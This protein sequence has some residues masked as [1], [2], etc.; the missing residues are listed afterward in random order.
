MSKFG[1]L[2]DLNIPVLLD[3]YTEWNEDS[4][5]MNPVLREVAASMGNK[6]KVIKIDV[7][8]N[9]QLAEALRVKTLPT[10]MI[11]KSGEMKWR[12]SG[13]QDAATLV[14]ILKEYV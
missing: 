11:Y 12:Q 7:D 4:K 6:V 3:F 8:K 9:S 13:E 10:L 1:E 2:I 5:A 14:G